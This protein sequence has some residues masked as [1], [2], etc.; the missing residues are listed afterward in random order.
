MRLLDD[1]DGVQVIESFGIRRQLKPLPGG[2][3]RDVRNAVATKTGAIAA[4]GNHRLGREEVTCNVCAEAPC[5]GDD[6]RAIGHARIGVIDNDRPPRREGL[7]NQMFL[8]SLRL[9]VVPH[10]ILADQ[11][12]RAR[13]VL[14]VE[15]GLA[16]RGQANQDYALHVSVAAG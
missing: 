8:P 11:V 6:C 10:R 14:A 2:E 1:G 12:V 16:R 3:D 13:K 15:S 7:G 9:P 5:N 4:K